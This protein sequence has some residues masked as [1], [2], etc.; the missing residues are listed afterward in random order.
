MD[1][2]VD[3]LNE[4]IEKHDESKRIA[5]EKI[6][7]VCDGLRKQIDDFEIKATSELEEMYTKEDESIQSIINEIRACRADGEKTDFREATKIVQ[8]AK[9]KLLCMQTYEFAEYFPKSKLDISR[10]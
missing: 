8:T 6:R 2:I 10:L 1:K 9:A 7:A 5:Q 4:R 3:A